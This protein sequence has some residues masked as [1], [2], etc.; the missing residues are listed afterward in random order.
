MSTSGLPNFSLPRH[1]TYKD[2]TREESLHR[3]LS[4][5]LV[6]CHFCVGQHYFNC[7]VEEETSKTYNVPTVYRIVTCFSEGEVKRTQ[8]SSSSY[9]D[10]ESLELPSCP[11]GA[12]WRAWDI[13]TCKHRGAWY[14]YAWIPSEE[15]HNFENTPDAVSSWLAGWLKALQA[16]RLHLLTSTAVS[17]MSV[18]TGR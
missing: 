8:D 15:A 10:H 2:E 3:F 14:I 4:D 9:V 17:F 1:K 11:L 16:K 18:N 5:R 6:E 12:K 7:H 13:F